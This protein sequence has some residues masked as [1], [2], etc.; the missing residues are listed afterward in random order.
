MSVSG[1]SQSSFKTPSQMARRTFLDREGRDIPLN[2]YYKF[3]NNDGN[4]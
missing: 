2:Y 3:I 4:I 1:F